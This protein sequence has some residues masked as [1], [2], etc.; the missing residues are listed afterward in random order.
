MSRSAHFIRRGSAAHA[1]LTHLHCADG[2]CERSSVIAAMRALLKNDRAA[3]EAY[4]RLIKRG[5]I[6][7]SMVRI[8]DAGRAALLAADTRHKPKVEG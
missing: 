3:E 6:E 1:A 8:T 4:S 7:T 2:V 5:Y